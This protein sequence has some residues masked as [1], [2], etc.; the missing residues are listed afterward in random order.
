MSAAVC[1]YASGICMHICILDMVLLDRRGSLK[2]TKINNY[3]LFIYAF[4]LYS[5]IED[6]N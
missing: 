5:V 4:F 3:M 6:L 2:L 1:L